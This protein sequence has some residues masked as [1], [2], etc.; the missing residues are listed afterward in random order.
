MAKEG[1]VIDII[2][3]QIQE[4]IEPIRPSVDDRKELDVGY[5]YADNTL[6]V[7]E[8]RP[9]WDNAEKMIHSP[10][11]RTKYIK[12]RGIWT[13]YWKKANG[14]WE[15]YDPNPEVN[16]LSQFFVILDEDEHCCFWG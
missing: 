4:F 1:K 15:K 3:R 11:A 16:D 7:F 5:T 12:S 8:I 13:I 2:H 10:V 9:H 6:E 14:K